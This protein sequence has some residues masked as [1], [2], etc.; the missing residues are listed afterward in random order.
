MAPPTISNRANA[1]RAG[2]RSR[3]AVGSRRLDGAVA[4]GQVPWP[5]VSDASSRWI[6]PRSP[7]MTRTISLVARH[8][9]LA[10]VLARTAGNSRSEEHTSELQSHVNLV[11]RLLL[12]KKNI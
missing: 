9:L 6:V 8:L 11:C 7:G 10:P 5:W 4:S 3:R 2:L 1:A 12:E